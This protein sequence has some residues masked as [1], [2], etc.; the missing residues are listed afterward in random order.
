LAAF[1]DWQKQ[2]GEHW[3]WLRSFP[4]IFVVTTRWKKSWNLMRQLTKVWKIFAKNGGKLGSGELAEPRV[5][6]A[7]VEAAMLTNWKLKD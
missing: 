7:W 1:Q 4:K 5:M 6:S 2:Y 3:I